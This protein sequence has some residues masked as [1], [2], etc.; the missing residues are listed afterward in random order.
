VHER[1]AQKKQE[2]RECKRIGCIFA[3]IFHAD[4][5]LFSSF[6]GCATSGTWTARLGQL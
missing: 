2:E 5:M 6:S 4:L 3:E 1:L